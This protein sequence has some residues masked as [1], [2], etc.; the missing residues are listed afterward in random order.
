MS[1]LSEP[2]ENSTQRMADGSGKKV[3]PGLDAVRARRATQVTQDVFSLN[4][5]EE[6]LIKPGWKPVWVR[7]P[8]YWQRNLGDPHDRVSELMAPLERGGKDAELVFAKGE[9]DK[10]IRHDL[11]LM[12]VPEA[13]AAHDQEIIDDANREYEKGLR[14]TT[15]YDGKGYRSDQSMHV[16]S[17]EYIDPRDGAYFD[18]MAHADHEQNVKMGLV[19]GRTAGLP[20]WKAEQ[21][22]KTLG[23]EQE[24]AAR[25]ESLAMGNTIRQM[26]YDQF[27]A[28]MGGHP[29]TP[30]G[31]AHAMGNSGLGKTTAQKLAARG[32]GRGA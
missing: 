10:I 19:G 26:D 22:M 31:R 11:C 24:T 27:R 21:M 23:L 7:D 1:K 4:P 32:A 5:D 2:L 9:A 12:Q 6:A 8:G 28:I 18:S 13:V 16:G 20:L 25:A 29:N 17:R 30:A 15:E 14:Q 3:I